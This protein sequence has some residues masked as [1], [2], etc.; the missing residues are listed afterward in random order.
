MGERRAERDPLLFA[1]GELVR[2]GVDPVC[3]PDLA[4]QLGRPPALLAGRLA[5]EREPERDELAG[6]Q[7]R[8]ERLRVALVRVAEPAAAV[9]VE[10]AAA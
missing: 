1:A 9:A 5:C 6:R 8:C 2:I 7:L 10:P 3:E 4:E